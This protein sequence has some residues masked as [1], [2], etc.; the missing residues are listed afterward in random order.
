MLVL[1]RKNGQCVR[2]GDTIEVKVLEISGNRVKLGFTA[3]ADLNIQREE[4]CDVYPHRG[5]PSRE[6]CAVG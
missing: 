2:I 6:C 4:I 5:E 1:S 3:P